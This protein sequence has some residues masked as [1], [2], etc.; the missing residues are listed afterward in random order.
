VVEFLLCRARETG[1]ETIYYVGDV[2][3]AGLR[4]ASDLSSDLLR[5]GVALVPWLPGYR[6]M[7][8][9]VKTHVDVRAEPAPFLLWLPEPERS[10]AGQVVH[11]DGHIAQELTGWSFLCR[12]WG[13]D[14][15]WRTNS[16]GAEFQESIL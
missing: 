11:A 15:S 13:I 12:L 4:I 2:D 8:G 6:E 1:A 9:H 5:N 14:P 7:L 10:L 3:R 16:A